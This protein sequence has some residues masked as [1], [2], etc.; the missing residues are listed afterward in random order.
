MEQPRRARRSLDASKPIVPPVVRAR[1]TFQT[2]F[3]RLTFAFPLLWLI[4]LA[5]FYWIVLGTIAV[6]YLT[7]AKLGLLA[8]LIL[9]VAAALII[10]A[11]IG[12]L[13][14]D[15][16]PSRLVGL[17]ANV[18]VWVATAAVVQMAET[19]DESRNMAR[20]LTVVGFGQGSVTL[21]AVIVYPTVLPVPLLSGLASRM[22]SGLA[23]F[24]ENGLYFSSWLE[25]PEFRSSGM[26]GQPTWA[27]AVAFL[28]LVAAVYLLAHQRERGIWRWVAI[29]TVPV[30]IVSIDLSLSRAASVGI[31]I[32]VLAGI[33]VWAR[34]RSGPAFFTLIVVLALAAGGVA[35]T[36]MDRIVEWVGAVNSLR[37]GSFDAR[38]QIYSATW[39]LIAEHPFQLLGYGIKPEGDE[40]V[41]HVATHSTYLGLMFRGG[42]LGL[43][44]LVSVY[45]VLIARS[46]KNCS[47]WATAITVFVAVWSVLEDMD[48]GHLLPLAIPL[49]ASWVCAEQ[50]PSETIQQA[51]ESSEA[52]QSGRETEWREAPPRS[53]SLRT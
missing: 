21:I 30:T 15:A 33:I 23:A 22:P 36:M 27:G 7:R 14:T 17:A 25:G 42:L 52:E 44:A 37:E 47:V 2:W 16:S 34:R 5:G 4:G 11:P 20:A 9:T 51:E 50:G 32:A 12:M 38:S 10:S 31:F 40:L 26:M 29:A 35:L 53:A 19:G 1:A 46:L 49:A 41:A 18:A 6:V 8:R 24:M 28:A 43:A 13:A 48:P 39:Q 45:V 3:Y